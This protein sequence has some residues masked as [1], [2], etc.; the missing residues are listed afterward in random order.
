LSVNVKLG[1]L[2]KWLGGIYLLEIV[3]LPDEER[4]KKK[5]LKA[6]Q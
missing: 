4:K 2:E 6:W 1:K 5:L 3:G